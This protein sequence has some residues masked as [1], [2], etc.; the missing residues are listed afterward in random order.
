[1][2]YLKKAIKIFIDIF[3]IPV[4]NYC[5][6]NS[7][8]NNKLFYLYKR[9]NEKINFLPEPSPILKSKLEKLPPVYIQTLPKSGTYLIGKILCELGYEDIEIHSYSEYIIDYRCHSYYDKLKYGNEYRIK[10][11]FDIQRQLID[12]GQFL[13]GHFSYDCAKFIPRD[14][15]IVCVRDLRYVCFSYLRWLQKCQCNSSYNW[16]NLGETEEALFTFMSSNEVINEIIDSAQE[17]VKCADKYPNKVIHF[18]EL[19]N[20]ADNNNVIN[21]IS[22]TTSIDN[23][24][25]YLAIKSSLNK[26]TLTYSGKPTRIDDVWSDRIEEIF[27]KSGLHFLN[28]VLGY[29]KNI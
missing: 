8:Y 5:F 18:E 17:S 19:I 29:Y 9:D 24:L 21:V 25:V 10:L 15:L 26:K 27:C 7:K 11:P 28:D 12:N 4:F 22:N 13:L 16:F 23:N 6:K 1:M 3:I 14:N 2:K 20:L